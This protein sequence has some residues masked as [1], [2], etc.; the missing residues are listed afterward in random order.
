[1][2]ALILTTDTTLM[3]TTPHAHDDSSGGHGG[4]TSRARTV[5]N[6]PPW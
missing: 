2:S 1:M 5:V 3:L 4:C 6:F